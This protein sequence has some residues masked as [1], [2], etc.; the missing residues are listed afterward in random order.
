[1]RILFIGQAV[2]RKGLPVLLRAF[3]ALREQIPATLT[4]VGGKD[5]EIAP[6]L[7]DGRGVRALGKV[8]EEQKREELRRAEVLCAPSLR[9]ESF[10]MVLTEA[11]AASAPVVASDIPGYRD[12]ARDGRA[13]ACS[14]R[15]GNALALAEAL[16]ALALD[17]ERRM[18]MA[19]A[20]RE[21]AGRFSWSH[22]AEEICRGL[23]AG[24]RRRAPGDAHRAHRRASRPRTLRI[25]ARAVRAHRLPSLEPAA[26]VEASRVA[27]ALARERCLPPRLPGWRSPTLP[28]R[29]LASRMSQ[30]A[31]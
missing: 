21:H 8:S 15:P 14:S 19:A 23:R 10:G 3:E 18:R 5:A 26:P 9:G 30:R 12:V 17:P 16:R 25:C 31:L 4:L 2:E 22:V 28:C 6:M 13:T 29:R 7:L 24:G 11:F 27:C 1:M 20:A